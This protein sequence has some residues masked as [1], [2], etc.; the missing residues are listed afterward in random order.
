VGGGVPRAHPF[1]GKFFLA[2]TFFIAIFFP[3][4]HVVIVGMEWDMLIQ[5]LEL[6]V[7]CEKKS[8]YVDDNKVI[9]DMHQLMKGDFVKMKK[10]P[11]MISKMMKNECQYCQRSNHSKEKC[12]W[13][14]NNLDKKLKEK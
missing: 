13:N 12:F 5:R 10:P 11:I 6:M 8:T 9:L 1:F 2:S 14:P 3:Y 7:V 4:L